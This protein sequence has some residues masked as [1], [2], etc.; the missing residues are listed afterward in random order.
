LALFVLALIRYNARKIGLNLN[1]LIFVDEALTKF[2][3]IKDSAASER[4]CEQ[5]QIK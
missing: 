2:H 3:E 5:G 1:A 4:Y